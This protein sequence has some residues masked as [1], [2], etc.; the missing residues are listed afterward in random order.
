MSDVCANL[1][2]TGRPGVGKTTVITRLA[3]QL[4]DRRITGFYTQEMREGGRRQG[5][6]ATTF[7]G[8]IIVLAHVEIRSRQRVG[9]YGVDVVA[10]EQLVL[11]EL[12][13][14]LLDVLDMFVEAGWPQAT[15][16]TYRLDE[17]FR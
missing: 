11:P 9:P 8:E 13:N 5:F 12:R 2:L 15:R 17:V 16:L 7:S 14:A 10:F 4:A 6:R 3:E 1:L